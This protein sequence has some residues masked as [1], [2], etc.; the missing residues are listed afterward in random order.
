MV[1][2]SAPAVGVLDQTWRACG[3]GIVGVAP[4]QEVD[5]DRE[6]LAPFWR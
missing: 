2:G 3:F 5:D 1:V 6:Q 4:E